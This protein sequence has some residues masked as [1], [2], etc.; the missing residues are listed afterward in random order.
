MAE[1]TTE[2]QWRNSPTGY[3]LLQKWTDGKWYS[4]SESS[5][6]GTENG[7]V[8]WQPAPWVPQDI[9]PEKRKWWKV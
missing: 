2:L 4:I 9:K 6:D 1:P 3:V 5:E 7:R 8:T